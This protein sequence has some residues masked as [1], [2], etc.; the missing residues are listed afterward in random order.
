MAESRTYPYQTQ[1]ANPGPVI[2]TKTEK[3][4]QQSKEKEDTTVYSR[5]TDTQENWVS[6]HDHACVHP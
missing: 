5:Q 2:Q 3:K 6:I 4:Q 1:M